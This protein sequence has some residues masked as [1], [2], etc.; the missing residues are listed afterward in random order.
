MIADRNRGETMTIVLQ[1]S[2]RAVFYAP[3]YAAFALEAYKAEGVAVE[4][5]SSPRPDDAARGLF[6]GAADVTWGG[7]MRVMLTYDQD[8]ACDLVGFCEVVTRDPFF[9]VG[10]TPRPDFRIADLTG[11]RLGSVSEVPT[12]WMCLQEDLRRAGQDPVGLNRVADRSMADNAAALRRGEL[13][14]V[15]LFQPFVEAL[16]ADGSGH[17]WYAAADRGPCSYTTFYTRRAVLEQRTDELHRMTRAIYR[18]QKWL[19]GAEP[20]ALARLVGPR[21]FPDVPPAH[22]VSAFQ[23]YRALGIWGRDPI[24]PRSGYD[25]LKAGLL[26]GGLV[27][28]DTP[29]EQAVDNRLAEAVVAEDPPAFAEP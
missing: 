11:L 5:A 17:L 10:R 15:Q 3:F 21:F 6:S 16:L 2:L 8:P 1:E 4:F 27:T 12:P 19:Q 25:R 18:T 13:D 26:S 24:L 20:A 9:L 29:F 28:R 22:L 14:V 7:P 23:R